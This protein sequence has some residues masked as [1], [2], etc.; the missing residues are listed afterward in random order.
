MPPTRTF[1]ILLI[2][3]SLLASANI[4]EAAMVSLDASP[5]SIPADG[6]SRAQVLVTLFDSSG[7]NVS[8]GTEVHLT[9]SAG[10]ITP[11]AYTSGGRAI[12]ILTSSET[13][14][15]AT[16]TV[17]ADGVTDSIQVEF[18]SPS[19]DEEISATAKTIRMEAG[20]LAYSVD[21]DTILASSGVTMEYGNLTI[22]ATGAQVCQSKSQMLAQGE[23]SIEGKEETL[24]ADALTCDTR[25]DHI[26]LIDSNEQSNARIYSAA[27]L[28]QIE[29]ND[30]Q[31]DDQGFIP[32]DDVDGK[33]W[34]ICDR[35]VL[36]PGEKI[37]FFKASI[38]VGEVKVISLPYYCYSYKEK[39]SI[40]QQVRYTSNDGILVD[41]P[42]YYHMS[43]SRTGALKLRYAANGA[44]NGGYYMPAKGMSLGLEQNYSLSDTSQGR[45]FVD[46][47]F[48]SSQAFELA[49]HLE[50]GSMMTGGRADISMRFQP[51]S[52]YAKNI[53]SSTLNV[54]GSLQHY[55]YTLT[56]YVGGSSILQS[57]SDD[58]EEY[59]GQ[60]NCSARAIFRPKSPIISNLIG[61]INP[62]FTL[63][64]G[65]LWSS[66]GDSTSSTL[67]HSLGLSTSYSRPGKQKLTTSFDT[68][69]SFIICGDSDM[70]ASLRLGPTLRNRWAGGNASLGYAYNIRTGTTDSSSSLS[71]HLLSCAFALGGGKWKSNSSVSYGLDSGRLNLSSNLNYRASSLWRM[72][73][74]YNLYSYAY[75]ISDNSYH[76]STS[77]LKVGLYRPLGPY[78][79][80]LAWSPDGQNYGIDKDKHLWLELSGSG[81]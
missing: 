77:Y 46:S 59:V 8:D 40:L 81:Y 42:F 51:S 53:Y 22:K 61:K 35:L 69:T 56:G 36:I 67:Y 78:E 75:T 48:G 39:E 74:S 72:K 31:T 30:D 5:T 62:S 33:T 18:Y 55:T 17:I 27:S 15:M 3:L 76:Y 38:Y 41:M 58:L 19:G 1:A 29:T 11:V 32:L 71:R 57:T 14:Q 79:V 13:P 10:D 63:G 43:D 7:A 2:G 73:C 68:K 54:T 65:K 26:R 70:G 50:F 6:K 37:L 25:T 64:Y 80:G 12:G 49:H 34:I 45:V 4:S 28:K 52:S 23:V 20:S 47:V 21:T 60:S 16:V 9:T 24:H 44:E 66:S